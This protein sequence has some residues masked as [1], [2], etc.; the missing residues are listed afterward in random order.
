MLAW[1]LEI[2]GWQAWKGMR[3]DDESAGVWDSEVHRETLMK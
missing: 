2:A 1:I 3:N